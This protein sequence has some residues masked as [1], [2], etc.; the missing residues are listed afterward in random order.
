MQNSLLDQLEF[1]FC[2]LNIIQDK[3][4]LGVCEADNGYASI[5]T[6]LSFSKIKELNATKENIIEAV[7]SSTQLELSDD[8]SKIKRKQPIP[9]NDEINTKSL[10]VKTVPKDWNT[11]KIREFVNNHAKVNSLRL[12][13]FRKGNQLEFSGT[14][15]VEFD[16]VEECNKFKDL[17]EKP[18]GLLCEGE[19]LS[20]KPR[21][22]KLNR[23]PKASK[24]ELVKL[25]VSGKVCNRDIKA[26]VKN[27]ELFKTNITKYA[28]DRNIPLE[29]KME[30][31][32][33]V[34]N[35][36]EEKVENKTEEKTEDKPKESDVSTTNDESKT[37]TTT[38]KK[39]NKENVKKPQTATK[40]VYLGIKKDV[41]EG[42]NNVEIIKKQLEGITMHGMK[43][44]LVECTEEDSEYFNKFIIPEKSKPK[45]NMKRSRRD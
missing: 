34:E 35:K 10:F 43:V 25:L 45:K 37:E 2:D 17:V 27:N 40:F 26:I 44:Q 28:V 24:I 36:T 1:Y 21:S 19:K 15:F 30:T 11:S 9:T 4:L 5:D 38:E 29:T 18:E 7:K 22:E 42:D 31:E 23:K 14:F 13:F 12:N 41:K 20:V 8:N 3:F 6:L 16:S 33:K 32:E 39:D